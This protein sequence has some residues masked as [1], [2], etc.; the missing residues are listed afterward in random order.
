[1]KKITISEAQIGD[2]IKVPI[3]DDG[4]FT[5][6]YDGKFY[7]KGQYIVATVIDQYK[8][9]WSD[10]QDIKIQHGYTENIK[11]SSYTSIYP[12]LDRF[13]SI[14]SQVPCVKIPSKKTSAGFLFACLGAGI[15]MNSL[16]GT[17][18]NS[19]A[20]SKIREIST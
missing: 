5:F 18:D 2:K 20:D 16:F 15:T 1:M 3:N 9:G 4:E 8:I 17:P 14:S 11:T 7:D 19:V 13:I 10:N 6:D 12:K